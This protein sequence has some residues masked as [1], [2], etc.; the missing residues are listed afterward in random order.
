M[1]S[2][3]SKKSKE[4]EVLDDRRQTPDRRVSPRR[5][6][7]RG[8]RTFWPNGDSAECTVYNFSE[9]GAKLGLLGH[10]PNAFDLA[11]DGDPLRRSCLVVWRKTNFVGVRFKNPSQLAP[12]IGNATRRSTADFAKYVEECRRL[13]QRVAPSDSKIL[14]EMAEAWKIVIR[15]LRKKARDVSV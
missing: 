5:K 10:A 9:T 8:G 1:E 11:I 7:L 14:L 13:A 6:V 12:S 2:V 4:P 15:R 3:A